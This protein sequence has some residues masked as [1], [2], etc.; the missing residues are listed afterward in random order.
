M[1]ECACGCHFDER[2]KSKWVIYQQICIFC[3]C[4]ETGLR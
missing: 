4:E 1:N 3:K 2:P